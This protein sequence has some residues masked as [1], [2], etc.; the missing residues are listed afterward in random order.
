MRNVE[1]LMNDLPA[2]EQ[3]IAKRLRNLILMA[4]PRIKEKVSYGVPYFFRNRRLFF[5]WPESAQPGLKKNK[6]RSFPKVTLG[7]CYGNLLSHHAD[8]MRDSRK[9]VFTI[10]I[11]KASDMDDHH[12]GEIIKEAIMADEQFFG[13]STR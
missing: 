11:S 5:I 12:V 4:E 7:F 8:L 9:Q 13:K 10:G 1:D 3:A 2:D 6:S